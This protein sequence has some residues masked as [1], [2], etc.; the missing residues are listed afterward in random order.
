VSVRTE[1]EQLFKWI[2]ELWAKK[3]PEPTPK[4]LPSEDWQAVESELHKASRQFA[5][6]Y[7]ALPKKY[8][9]SSVVCEIACD[10]ENEAERLA[11]R[12][13][14][15]SRRAPRTAAETA[16]GEAHDAGKSKEPKA[17]PDPV[18]LIDGA[19]VTVETARQKLGAVKPVDAISKAFDEELDVLAEMTLSLRQRCEFLNRHPVVEG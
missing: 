11:L 17:S 2:S 10:L 3:E 8:P 1:L 12:A 13:R 9:T 7:S 15:L 14:L 5:A 18:G 16:S 6:A 19:Q 4:P